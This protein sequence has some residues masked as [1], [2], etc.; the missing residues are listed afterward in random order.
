MMREAINRDEKRS[1]PQSTEDLIKH[2]VARIAKEMKPEKIILFGS[3]AWGDPTEASDIDLFIVIR[4]S[5]QPSYKRA[6]EVYR[7]LRGITAPVEVIIQ[8]QE[9]VDRGKQVITSLARK[10]FNE[11]KV[12]YG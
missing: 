11:G 4:E 1:V 6:Q 12:L 2:I 7:M 8:T 10:V 3:H 9:E 5:S